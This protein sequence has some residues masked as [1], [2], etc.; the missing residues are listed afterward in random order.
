M[1]DPI[2][3]DNNDEYVELYNRGTN[4]VDLAGWRLED[5]VS[6][7]FA[8]GMTLAPGGY[9]V[10]GKNPQPAL[11]ELRPAQRDEHRRRLLRFARKLRRPP[12]PSPCRTTS[13]APTSWASWSTN[14]IHIVISEVTYGSG[15]HWG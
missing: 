10:V 1:Y 9:L 8:D 4:A 14:K 12:S 13:R 15:G 11:H 3:G 2:S 6:Y 5:A 7:E